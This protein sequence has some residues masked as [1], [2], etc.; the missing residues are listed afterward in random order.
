MNAAYLILAHDRPDLA[1]RLAG[2][3]DG[4]AWL[5]VIAEE[6]AA[7]ASMIDHHRFPHPDWKGGG[8][9]RVTRWNDPT[10]LDRRAVRRAGRRCAGCRAN[11]GARA[12]DSSAAPPRRLGLVVPHPGG[13]RLRAGL[14]RC[15]LGAPSRS[16]TENDRPPD[17]SL[18]R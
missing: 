16:F 1:A 8:W 4:P 15:Q 18:R 2:A 11:G 3:L 14:L 9:K 6:M 13:G 12:P 10:G 17:L 5:P 7:R